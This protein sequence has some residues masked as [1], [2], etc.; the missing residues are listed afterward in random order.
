MELFSSCSNAAPTH[1]DPQLRT[2]KTLFIVRRQWRWNR[3][4]PGTGGLTGEH[5]HRCAF[6]PIL[7][8][9]R[10]RG[11]YTH[12][13]SDYSNTSSDIDHAFGYALA[14]LVN[15]GDAAAH[16]YGQRPERRDDER[17]QR[18]VGHVRCVRR[19]GLVFRYSHF[20]RRRFC[21]DHGN[22]WFSQ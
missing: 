12:K 6:P 2:R 5:C 15:R 4:V 16:R 9:R 21:D 17:C 10:W 8:G 7:W 1:S 3:G 19:D 11:I 13:P 20:G 18:V 22:V 14:L